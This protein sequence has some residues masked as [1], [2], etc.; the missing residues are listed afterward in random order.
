MIIKKAQDEIQVYLKDASNYKGN[1]S[2]VYFPES[3]ADVISIL[4]DAGNTKTSVTITG[5]R[6]GLTG[7][8]V[9]EGGIVVSTERMNKIIE[10]NKEEKFVLLEP[11]VLLGDLQNELKKYQLLYPPDPTETTC[12]VGGTVATNASGARTFKYGPT[13]DYVTGLTVILA[14]GE[15]LNLIR[16]EN[17][18]GN[19]KLH[20]TTEN[21]KQIEIA[22]PDIDIPK[23][24]NASGYFCKSNMDAIDLFVG[25]EG[26]LGVLTKLNLKVMSMPKRKISCV[27]FFKNEMDGLNFVK[28]ARDRSRKNRNELRNTLIDAL[29][30]DFFDKGSLELLRNNFANIPGGS[31]SAV[32][33][34]QEINNVNE[35]KL[36]EEWILII[37]A[38]N[39]SEKDCWFAFNENEEQ[40]IKNFRH[41]I[42]EKINEYMAVRNFRKLGTDVAVPHSNFEALYFYA[43]QIT[44]QE[45][46]KFVNYGHFGNSHMHFNFLPNNELQYQKSKELYNLICNKAI[47]LKGTISAE[48]GI[49]KTKKHLLLKMYGQETVDKMKTIKKILDPN[50][51]LGKG[52][53]FL[54]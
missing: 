1:C 9:P 33:F 35:D 6:T 21:G 11:G 20:L 19:N 39:G 38:C 8:G 50:L 28:Q 36:L 47:L 30:L 16:G 23:T 25:S 15:K 2:A 29:V 27:V 24:K 54:E 40:R 52:N 49:G 13:R 48:H 45:G 26:T 12:F 37:N 5:N 51:I 41:S 10:I 22:L 42:S 32:W 34:E 44:E 53:L 3:E 46:I 18:A 4:K 17:F 43:K 31:G 14:G 7:A